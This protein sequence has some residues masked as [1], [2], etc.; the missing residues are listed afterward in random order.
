MKKSKYTEEQIAFALRQAQMGS[1][2]GTSCKKAM[3]PAH[4]RALA[5]HMIDAYR[6]SKRR[7]VQLVGLSRSCCTAFR[8]NYRNGDPGKKRTA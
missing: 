3:K 1:R 6:C 2:V 4:H 5:H 8:Q 7:A